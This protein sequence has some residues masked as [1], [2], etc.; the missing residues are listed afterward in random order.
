MSRFDFADGNAMPAVKGLFKAPTP[1]R[2]CA[3]WGRTRV[4]DEGRA[5]GSAEATAEGAPLDRWRC[6][7]YPA[8]RQRLEGLSGALSCPGAR[9]DMTIPS[10]EYSRPKRKPKRMR[11]SDGSPSVPFRTG[12]RSGRRIGRHFSV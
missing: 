11:P 6:C 2:R 7:T 1:Y 8:Q 4:L 12:E 9:P 10:R 3:P 5:P